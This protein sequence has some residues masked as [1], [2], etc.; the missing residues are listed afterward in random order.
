M[1]IRLPKRFALTVPESGQRNHAL[2]GRRSSGRWKTGWP[3]SR[4]GSE[5][6]RHRLVSSRRAGGAPEGWPESCRPPSRR[7][8]IVSQGRRRNRN[9]PI[10]AADAGAAGAAD[11]GRVRD[12]R[13]SR[14]EPPQKRV[15]RERI[16]DRRPADHETNLGPHRRQTH[17]HVRGATRVL[18]GRTRGPGHLARAMVRSPV[19]GDGAV[20]GAVVAR[21]R[22]ADRRGQAALATRHQPVNC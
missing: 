5:R 22:A 13:R 10:R 12:S 17:R 21:N 20:E 7:E 1:P 15:R 2:P 16:P 6:S 18:H 11:A 8:A 3:N 19:A 4:S 14:V 9:R